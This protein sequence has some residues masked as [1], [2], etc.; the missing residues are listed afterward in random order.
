MLELFK[1]TRLAGLKDQELIILADSQYAINS[2]SKWM[3]GWKRRGWKKADGKPV[4]NRQILEEL[5][6]EIQGRRYRFEWVKGHAGHELNELADEKAKAAA[7]AHQARRRARPGPGFGGGAPET[8]TDG[9]PIQRGVEGPGI[10]SAREAHNDWEH[11]LD[12]A[13]TE[14]VTIVLDDGREL[15]LCDA[16]RG[17]AILE[18]I[19]EEELPPTLF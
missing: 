17:R 15:F 12:A 7:S 8:S 4:A 11:V 6:R 5:D 10:I 1:A 13:Y 19:D 16:P 3:P 18:A 9:S 14:P 2:V